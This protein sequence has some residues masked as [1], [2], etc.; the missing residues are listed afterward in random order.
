MNDK[1]NQEFWEFMYILRTTFDESVR[2]SLA[3]WL[4]VWYGEEGRER[5]IR[6]DDPDPMPETFAF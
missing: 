5:A 2:S 4:G 3:F 1:A 6:P